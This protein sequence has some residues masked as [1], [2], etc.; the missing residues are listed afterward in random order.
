ID[1]H[2]G[3]SAT[4]VGPSEGARWMAARTVVQAMDE[5]HQGVI[6]HVGLCHMVIQRFILAARRCLAP[7]HPLH[8][9]FAPHFE[10]TLA[11]NQVARESVVSPGGTQDRL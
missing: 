9:L 4:L 7:W 2:A 3:T 5:S 6:T 11:V 8:R 10:N 1:G